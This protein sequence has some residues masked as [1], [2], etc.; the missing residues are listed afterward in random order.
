MK[1]YVFTKLIDKSIVWQ[2]T[3]VDSFSVDDVVS[4]FEKTTG[5]IFNKGFAFHK[6]E[7]YS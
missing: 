4:L 3:V 5:F 2:I 7:W 6:P 1:N